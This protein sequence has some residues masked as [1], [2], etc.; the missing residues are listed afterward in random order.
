MLN[1]K[2]KKYLKIKLLENL[3]KMTFNYEYLLILNKYIMFN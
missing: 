2:N 1:R 3:I